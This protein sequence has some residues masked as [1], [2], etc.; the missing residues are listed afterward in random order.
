MRGRSSSF[1]LALLLASFGAAAQAQV[2]YAV[3]GAG[4]GASSLYTVN[5]ITGAATLV[6]ATGMSHMTGLDFDPTTGV[7]YGVV[8]S[9]FTGTPQLVTVNTSTGAATVVG[10][11]GGSFAI[12]DISFDPSG[13]LYAWGDSPDTLFTINK[14]TGVATDVGNPNGL[15]TAATGLAFSSSGTL[16]MKSSS[17]L[18]TI[19]PATGADL[20]GP[21]TLT[22]PG[23]SPKNSL[24][25]DWNTGTLYTITGN[26]SAGSRPSFLATIDPVG[27]T[28]TTI[29]DMGVLNM[30]ALAISAVPEPSGLA[31]GVALAAV[32]GIA[33]WRGRRRTREKR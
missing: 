13:Q 1:V 21:V 30:S 8:D 16:Y 18:F 28:W 22:G 15:G 6:G 25:F 33:S 17:D 32:G 27:G 26:N 19:N 5:P 11:L 12:P 31:M 2:I 14:A 10:A 23:D 4:G 9:G 24:T 20:T 3:T 7:L 29:G